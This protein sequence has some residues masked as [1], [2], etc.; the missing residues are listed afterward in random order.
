MT[1]DDRPILPP[2]TDVDTLMD[3]DTICANLMSHINAITDD[4]REQY[5]DA[6]LDG[7]MGRL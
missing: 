2:Q 7:I 4:H 6:I 5:A 1:N 3:T